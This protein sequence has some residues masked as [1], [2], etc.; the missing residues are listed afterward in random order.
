MPPDLFSDMAAPD[1]GFDSAAS[2]Q[3][4]PAVT[5]QPGSS[6]AMDS[7]FKLLGGVSQSVASGLVK[8]GV[9]GAKTGLNSYLSGIVSSGS[10][11]WILLGA[12]AIVAVILLKK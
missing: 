5:E 1:S 4:Y 11:P 12:A 2:F 9:S 3:T 7:I 8:G 6:G 10:G